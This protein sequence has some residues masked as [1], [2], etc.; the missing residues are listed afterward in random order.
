MGETPPPSFLRGQDFRVISHSLQVGF[1][2]FLVFLI[3]KCNLLKFT[4][5]FLVFVVR[6]LP[7]CVQTLTLT[8]ING[9]GTDD[10]DTRVEYELT[11]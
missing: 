7:L 11:A 5:R 1:G 6:V 8:E 2:L 3:C 10:Q 9:E 4:R